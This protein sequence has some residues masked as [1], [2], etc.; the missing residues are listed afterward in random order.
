MC[1]TIQTVYKHTTFR[2]CKVKI[3]LNV[4]NLQ[5]TKLYNSLVGTS[6]AIC[7]LSKH[8]ASFAIRQAITPYLLL[9]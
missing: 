9:T 5:V 8:I 2:G 3:L 7:S 1:N 6:E 4:N